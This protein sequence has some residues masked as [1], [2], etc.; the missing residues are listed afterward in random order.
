MSDEKIE[1]EVEIV[2]RKSPEFKNIEH[3]ATAGMSEAEA[4]ERNTI[5]SIRDSGDE[6]EESADV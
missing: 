2:T 3:K 5:G 4:I 6:Q 1:V